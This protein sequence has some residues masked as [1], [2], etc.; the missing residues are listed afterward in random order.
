MVW[1]CLKLQ[2]RH[3]LDAAL[4]GVLDDAHVGNRVGGLDAALPGAPRP[5]MMT[6]CMAAGT[7]AWRRPCRARASRIEHDVDFVEHH[8]ADRRVGSGS[9]GAS[10]P[11]TRRWRVGA[12]VL[13]FPGKACSPT[14]ASRRPVA[15]EKASS[16]VSEQALHELHDADLQAVAEGAGDTPKAALDL[17]LPLPVLTTS[18]PRS[19]WA[20]AILPSTRPSS[21][22][23]VVRVYGHFL[24]GM[25]Q[26]GRGLRSAAGRSRRVRTAWP[27]SG[28]RRPAK[29]WRPRLDQHTPVAK[30]WASA[31]SCRTMMTPAPQS[32]A[33]P[34]NSSSTAIWW[35][36]SRCGEGFV[37][38]VERCRLDEQRGDGQALAFAA[39]QGVDLP[40]LHAGQAHRARAPGPAS[41][42]AR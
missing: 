30:R 26:R 18:T 21:S 42:S 23:C 4:E 11:A 24:S 27:P 8:Q 33:V 13:G 38:Q 25:K 17:P 16:P 2:P 28:S 9:P 40:L 22:A 1:L 10:Q 29:A 12:S 5:V 19:S 39:R 3:R 35:L 14:R 7:A 20:A 15:A 31:G 36:R 32:R 37:E 41:S 34:A 6:C